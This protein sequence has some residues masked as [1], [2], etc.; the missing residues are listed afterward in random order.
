MHKYVN[1]QEPNGRW[2]H[3]ST[4]GNGH[5]HK[6]QEKSLKCLLLQR[7]LENRCLV[8]MSFPFY[9][10]L[11]TFLCFPVDFIYIIPP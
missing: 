1:R 7:Y 6:K 4:Y 8:S 3:S 11:Y 10:V 9:Y 2:C 5:I